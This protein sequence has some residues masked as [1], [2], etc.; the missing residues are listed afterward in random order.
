MRYGSCLHQTR[1]MAGVELPSRHPVL[2]SLSARV[3]L[4]EDPFQTA[5]TYAGRDG[6]CRIFS[7]SGQTGSHSRQCR[8]LMLVTRETIVSNRF[9]D[10]H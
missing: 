5:E 1:E 8:G 7:V 2:G 6:T 9:Y 3:N 4:A 10:T